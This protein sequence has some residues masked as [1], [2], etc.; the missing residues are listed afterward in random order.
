M[1]RDHAP[2]QANRR[3]F[4]LVELL[5]V[6]AIIATLI[7]LLLP[8]VQTA[9]EAARRSACSNNLKQ[10][11]VGCLTYE[12]AKRKLPPSI[13]RTGTTGNANGPWRKE[14]LFTLILP[15]FEE[16]AVYE[17]IQ[18]GNLTGSTVLT[19]PA[20]N[21]VVTSY[22]CPSYPHPKVN[23]TSVG[24]ADYENGAM[25]TYSGCGGA[26]PANGSAAPCLIGSTY[27][28]NGAFNL[29]GPGKVAATGATC[30]S[31]TTV[32]GPGRPIKQ[33][34]DGTSKSFMI[35]E[36]CHRDYF[37]QRNE[38]Q[39][40]PGNMRPWFLAGNYQST[41]P[42]IYHVKEFELTP[43]SKQTRSNAGGLNKLPMG[44]YH[45]DTTLFVMVDGSVRPVN[46]SIELLVYQRFATVNGG[47]TVNDLQ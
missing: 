7:G 16:K 6:I 43:N 15:F 35:G 41:V 10:I 44:S 26:Q 13:A 4:T 11:G 40:P 23:T 24:A 5:V 36:Y 33:V 47:E 12:S 18:F 37:I 19:D 45:P 34:S 29:T 21:Q 2:N 28:D 31:G 8:A 22:I 3:G 1:L 46:D 14:G 25:I 9:R 20:R 42:E 39:V 30:G 32:L 38:W 17:Q 27:P